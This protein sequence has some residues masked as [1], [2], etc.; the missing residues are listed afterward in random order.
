MALNAIQQKWVDALRSGEYKQGAGR[1]RYSDDNSFCCL[2]VLC[3]LAAQAGVIGPYDPL[4]GRYDG[5]SATLPPSVMG[6]A[7][8][9]DNRGRYVGQDNSKELSQENDGGKTFAEIADI[10][11]SEP[12]KLF[13]TEPA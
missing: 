13:V 7:G 10:I 4:E 11:A 2:G 1:L 6:W 3:E 9:E 5:A 12:E 8:L